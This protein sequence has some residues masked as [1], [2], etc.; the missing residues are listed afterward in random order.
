MIK[1]FYLSFSGE[2]GMHPDDVL[3]LLAEGEK[4]ASEPGVHQVDGKYKSGD[5]ARDSSVSWVHTNNAYDILRPFVEAAND[6]CGWK[7]DIHQIEGVQLTKY[8]K[9]QHY[10]WHIDGNSDTWA[11]KKLVGDTHTDPLLIN[12]TRTPEFEGLVRK[13]SIIVQLSD[14]EDYKGGDVFISRPPKDGHLD[15]YGETLPQFREK[16]T[17]I[18]FPSYARHK[19]TPV[20]EGV[21]KSAV[22]WACGPPFK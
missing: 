8:N 2:L 11:A 15:I 6:I 14:P 22:A 19:V 1:H 10:D 16:G 12:Q 3:Y 9:A 20:T 13:L 7:Y 18:V 17:V 21:R 4:S 5:E